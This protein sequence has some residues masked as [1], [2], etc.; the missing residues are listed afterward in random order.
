MNKLTIILLNI[1]LYLFLNN[2]IKII[3]II[4]NK[5]I[6]NIYV[7]KLIKLYFYILILF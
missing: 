4:N 1:I 7:I 5:N 2:K 6:F 3:F